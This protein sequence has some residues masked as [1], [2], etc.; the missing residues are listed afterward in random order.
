MNDALRIEL[1]PSGS[2]VILT[3][4]GGIDI[5]TVGRLREALAYVVRRWE[6]A[7]VVLDLGAVNY[8][9]SQG[10]RVLCSERKAASDGGF[11]LGIRRARPVVQRTLELMGVAEDF[12]IPTGGG[13]TA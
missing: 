6:P 9:D 1:E 12:V 7:T 8:L 5:S 10:V 3:M 11:V 4:A 13:D 2:A